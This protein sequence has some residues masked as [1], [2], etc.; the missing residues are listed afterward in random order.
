LQT[1]LA[2]DGPSIAKPRLPCPAPLVSIVNV[3][4]SFVIACSRPGP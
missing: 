4:G 3:V 2:S 1:I